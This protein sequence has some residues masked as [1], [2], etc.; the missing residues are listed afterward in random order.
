M[1]MMHRLTVERWTPTRRAVTP[2]R[3]KVEG[4]EPGITLSRITMPIQPPRLRGP[5][6]DVRK[7]GRGGRRE[8][9]TVEE[10]WFE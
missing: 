6:S 4:E 1:R 2:T 8:S 3:A 9:F 5:K 7:K 10:Q